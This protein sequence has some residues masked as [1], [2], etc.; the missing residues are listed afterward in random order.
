MSQHKTSDSSPVRLITAKQA[1][2]MFNVSTDWLYSLPGHIA[3]VTM[4]RRMVR[5]DLK[6]LEA[7]FASHAG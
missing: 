3:R 1:S 5:F 6:K 2:E 4:G 7:F